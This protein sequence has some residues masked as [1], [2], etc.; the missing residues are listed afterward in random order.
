MN[1]QICTGIL[2]RCSAPMTVLTMCRALCQVCCSSYLHLMF[3]TFLFRYS[4]VIKKSESVSHPVVVS[5]SE[6]PWNVA[7]QAPLPM[8][9]SRQEYWICLQ[10]RRHRRLR[11]HPRVGKIP[12]R[13][14]WHSS[15]LV[16]KIP[17]AEEPGGLRSM[18][19]Q[20]SGTLL[21]QLSTHTW[22]KHYYSSFTLHWSSKISH[23]SSQ[24][25]EPWSV[26]LHNQRS[27]AHTTPSHIKPESGTTL[28][29]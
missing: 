13:R 29:S 6:T 2:I 10:C 8:E 22:A 25:S 9:F 27:Y 1:N 14:K 12:W 11:F 18:G 4:S 16:W 15:I 24:S 17:W 3:L 7:R 20:N 28:M 26:W 23:L 19:S 21:K 5:D